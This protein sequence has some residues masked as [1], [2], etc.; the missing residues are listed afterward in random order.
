MELADHVNKAAYAVR[1]MRLARWMSMHL[2]DDYERRVVGRMVLVF[3]PVY[4]D[5]AFALLKRKPGLAQQ[6]RTQLRNAIRR[7]R[8]DFE[9]YYDRIRHDLAAHR[10][11]L[12]LDVAVEA[13][14][15]IDSDTLA[16]FCSAVDESIK[17]IIGR[18]SLVTGS[19]KDFPDMR[20][21]GFANQL[22]APGKD[23]GTVRFST[24]ALS[25]TRGHVGIVPVH[26]VQNSA[27]ILKSVLQSMQIC[28]RVNEISRGRIGPHLLL[29]TMFIIDAMNLVDGVFGEPAGASPKRS[30]SFLT[31]LERGDFGGAASLRKSLENADLP[32]IQAVRTIRNKAC[33]HLDPAFDLRQLQSLVLDLDDAV[34]L[35]RVVNPTTRALEEACAADMTTRWLLIDE[36]SLAGIKLVS[37]PGVRPFD[38]DKRSDSAA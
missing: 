17:D 12:A 34:I 3:A 13:W 16:W 25:M 6:D 28:L 23:A 5:S 15:E 14:N 29:K 35:D 11:A 4:I 30:A 8:N 27:A 31:I 19:V 32:A 10:D 7:L 37:A 22:A 1:M 38:R 21:E 33:A 2:A 26:E 20:D 9:D 18:H 24:D 36:P